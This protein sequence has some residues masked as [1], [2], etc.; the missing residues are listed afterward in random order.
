MFKL[1]CVRTLRGPVGPAV[2]K[3]TVPSNVPF[4]LVGKVLPDAGVLDVM[5]ACPNRPIGNLL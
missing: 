5:L 4:A 1:T 3:L 2:V